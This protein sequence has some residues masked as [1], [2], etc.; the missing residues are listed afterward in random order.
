MGSRVTAD[1]SSFR[2]AGRRVDVALQESL[3]GLGDFQ[4]LAGPRQ[5]DLRKIGQLSVLPVSTL[6]Q[7]VFHS[8]RDPDTNRYLPVAHSTSAIFS[9]VLNVSIRI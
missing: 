7:I 4:L 3:G 9:I 5:Q 2:T 6:L 1:R 8:L